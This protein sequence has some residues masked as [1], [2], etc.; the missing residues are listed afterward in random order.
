MANN[1]QNSNNPNFTAGLPTPLSYE[2]ILSN[3]LSS[4]ASSIGIN[5]F[6]VG[7]AVTSFFETVALAV[8]RSSGDSFQI[9][10]TFSIDRATGF[11]LQNL[12]IENGVTPITAKPATGNVNI[13][14]TSFTKISSKI[15]AGTN[16]P[17][18]GSTTINISDASLFPA[19]GSLYIGRGTPNIEGPIPYSLITPFGGYFIITLSAPTTKFHNLGE[20]VIVS[21]GGNRNIPVNTVVISPASG[22][23]A[24]IQFTVTTAAIILDGETSVSGV[25]V[26]ALLPGASGNVPAGAITEFAAPPFTG[27]T[28]TNPLSFTTGSDTETDDQL[29][30]R[31]K[32][33][34]ASTGLGTATAVQAAVIGATPSDENATVVSDS[35]VI[36]T[37]GSATLYIDDGT[38][39]EEKSAGVG[40]ESIVNSAL[41]GEQFFQLATG[42]RQAPV[43]KAFLQS[44]LSA[45][46]DIIG[47]D[48]LAIT[49]G[50]QTYQHVFSN[51][52]FVSPGAATA[53]E[54]I[55]SVNADSTL[56]FQATTAGN[57]SFVV[58]K[59]I[60]ESNDSLQ[61]VAPSTSGRN[62]AILLGLPSGIA[63]TLRLY[64]NNIPLSKD[65]NIAEIFTQS[66]TFWS[67]GIANGDT[68]IVSV[69]GTSPIT[70]TILDSDFI[71]T[72]LY[73]NVSANNSL[74]S[75]AQV[76]NAKLTGI[77]TS[78]VGSQL[79]LASNLGANNRANVII[80]S[81]STLVTKGMF[82]GL[83]SLVS[84]G[85]ASDFTLDRNTAQ[86]DL[87]VPLVAGDKLE[88]GSNMTEAMVESSQI[89]SGSVTLT[90]NGHIWILVDNPGTLIST[91]IVSNTLISVSNPSTNIVRYTSSVS[92]AFSNVLLGDYVIIWSNELNV[93]NR[94]EGRVNAVTN[95]TLDLLVTSAEYS[96]SV[97]QTGI[98]FLNGFVVLRSTRAPQ[99]F[100]ITSGTNTLD[101]IA[102]Q[103]Q[104]QTSSL[105]IT[106][107]QE[108]NII[109]SSTTKNITG[110][111][112][113]VTSDSQGSLLD[114]ASGLN[115]Q[116]TSS[117]IAFDDSGDYDAEMPIFIHSEFASDAFADPINSFIA[118]MVSA[119]SF[120]N[121]DPNQLIS[122]LQPYGSS[123]D[124]QPYKEYAQ[125]TT[126]SGTS[127]GITQNNDIRRF[128]S[129]IDRFFR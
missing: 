4:Y 127:V 78:V 96:A 58:F 50:E 95:T 31:I 41:G 84:K 125:V 99:K 120:S 101:Q 47:G 71:A 82:G 65:G 64:K 121:I 30:V 87:V 35:I 2:Q 6:N 93:N 11:A 9:L 89:T 109:I 83:Q 119:I 92:T 40:L 75:W 70:Y 55:G 21:Q 59:A 43:A 23:S 74:A 60:A 39:Y 69:D 38:G 107:A 67:N 104:A 100:Q 62:A 117:L 44:T 49:V 103:L 18:I 3:M 7:S 45:P 25:Q 115:S 26:S 34:L 16:P 42:G 86:F 98:T 97:V 108:Q 36:N 10:T 76:L 77:T 116:A 52:D 19:T 122:I 112:L 53:Y 111:V 24:D 57:G 22:S 73:T 128:R 66:Q 15:Y 63:E 29:R 85:K 54:I 8:A 126:I 14:D 81:S 20:T 5:D 102:Q 17:N 46:F 114:I 1:T 90:S 129:A 28:V 61:I 37:D 33:A 72:G 94:L 105:S 51:S 88:A 110:S 56:G 113:I 124:S 13:I 79:V 27:A 32:N 123:N 106:I 80:S 48:T 118:S 91:G 68:L 12:A